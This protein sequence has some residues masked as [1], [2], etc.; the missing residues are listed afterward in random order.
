MDAFV[1]RRKVSLV[2]ILDYGGWS[3]EI[4]FLRLSQD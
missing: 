3:A 1:N 4:E 2:F